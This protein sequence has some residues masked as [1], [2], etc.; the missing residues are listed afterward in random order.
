[1]KQLKNIVC[2]LMTVFL[3]V[4]EIVNAQQTSI[5]RGT[6]IDENKEP[7]IGA[8][9]TIPGSTIGT[10]TD[11]DGIFRLAN[12]PSDAKTL[13]ISYIGYTTQNI[14]IAGKTEVN[15]QLVSDETA[16][17]ELVVVGYGTQK[18]AH[19]TGAVATVAPS[20][21]TDLSS[22][23]LAATLQGLITGVSVSQSSNRPGEP[24][25]ISIRSGAAGRTLYVI[26][27]FVCPEEDG[28]R[29]FNNLD[30]NMIENVS[31]LKDAAA[32]VY[33]ARSAEGVVLVTTK[34]GQVGKP[35]ISYQGQFGYTDEFYRSKMMDSYNFGVTWNA[36]RAADPTQAGFKPDEHLFQA[37]ELE[38][39][40]SLNYDLL[41]KYWSSALVQKHSVNMSGG[42]ESATYFGGISYIT[43]DG[44]MGKIN[45]DRWN[46]SAGMDAKIN[47]WTKASLRVSGDYGNTIKSNNKV[48][49]TNAEKDYVTLLTR[50]RYIPEYVT[51][52]NGEQ[53]P[54][55]SYGI[56]NG[57]LEQSQGY[58]YDVI[59]N[60]DNFLKN[61][62]QNMSINGSLEYD[63]GWS[64]ILKGLKLKGTY[65]KNISTAKDNEY[66]TKYTLYRF[67]DGNRG[68]SAHHLYEGTD[69]YPLNFN[70]IS[71]VTMDNGNYLRRNMSRSDSYQ[72]NFI[73]SYARTFGL[74]EVSGLFTI[75]K[76]ERE[77]EYVWGNVS[78]PYTFTNFQ[79]NGASGTQQTSFSRTESGALSYVGRLNY[80]YADRYLAEFLIRSD[81]STKFAPE[82]YWGVFPSLSLGW[83][84]SEEAWFKNKVN[85]VD[86]LKIRGSFGMLGRDALNAWEWAQFYSNE[87][88]K[89]PIFGNNPDQVAGPHFQLP[90]NVPNRNSHW[91]K[92]YKSNLGV[93]ANFLRNRLSLTLDGYYDR[94]RDEFLSISSAAYYPTTVG[95]T[96]SPSNWG[97]SDR[98]G[99]EVSL[100][101]RD[102]IGKDIKY[103]LKLNT[104]FSD[105]KLIERAWP[106]AATFPLNGIVKGER[107][108]RGTWGYECIGMFR[109]YQEIAE[110]FAEKNLVTYMGKSQVDVHPGMLIYND[111]RGSQKSDGSY[112]A[113]GD[114]D[115]PNGNKVDSN[116]MVKISNRGSNI[117]GFTLNFGGEYKNL[118]L[119]A[120]LGAS[121]GSYATMPSQA[122]KNQSVVST[123]S[124]YDVMQYTNLPSFWSSN[125]FVYE[126]VLDAQGRVVAAQNRDALYPNL[127]FADVNSVAST[128]WRINNTNV[129]LRN[130]TLA[131]SL[132]KAW[133]KKVG[134]ASCRINITGQNLLDFYNP[135]PDKF[136]SQNSSYS[137]YPTLRK[138][139]MGLNVSF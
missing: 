101:W 20:E 120:Q 82:N 65:S 16:L 10:T 91:D 43:Q 6:V 59:E 88:I 132:P 97:A 78:D 47:N 117:Y 124:G 1:M 41:D 68:G 104:G 40:K 83:V 108:D 73:V 131:Y 54:I 27:G 121:W 123:G 25:R 126:D 46:Y 11:L 61:M 62:P 32:A 35:K 60:L 107:S 24:A 139:T 112:Y 129:L 79:S 116:D 86:F 74:N 90:N 55:A 70:N 29:M 26:D 114:P 80:V 72:L 127:R 128:F 45:Y 49:G 2:L 50:P 37:D 71:T 81:A 135:Y 12:V 95:A 113:P 106:N 102:K 34:R 44:N 77:S 17:E 93:D 130:V 51:A 84:I 5:L 33:G 58:H 125:M 15:V 115:D 138:F 52:P 67:A 118:S 38:A 103:W 13:R 7:V 4:P 48:G 63:F 122:I 30:P 69:G 105:D 14:D 137:V 100:G 87:V 18:K 53:L 133:V 66:G 109:N 28:E 75:E 21:I 9:V 3:M 111:I 8:N 98:Y 57:Q 85:F 31:V 94:Y 22:T 64:N 39:M 96:A 76:A 42:N 56:T 99:V 110:Y 134:I 19:L 23:S 36:I 89:G 136:M 92:S 119:S